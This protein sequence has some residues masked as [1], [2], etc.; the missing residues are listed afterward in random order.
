MNSTNHSGSLVTYAGL[1]NV[2][3]DFCG[4]HLYRI[5]AI[6]ISK[7]CGWSYTSLHHYKKKTFLLYSQ[8]LPQMHI[9]CNPDS[10]KLTRES[11]IY[12]YI[13][14]ERERERCPWYNGYCRRKWTQRHEFKS[15]TR[16]IAFSHS[17]NTL[18]KGMNPI[19]LPPAMGK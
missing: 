10:S 11:I 9:Y 12:I 17:P 15:W 13:Y 3:Q 19:I 18:G 7:K 5:N 4:E 8:T 2:V 6:R 16:L 1:R 14:I